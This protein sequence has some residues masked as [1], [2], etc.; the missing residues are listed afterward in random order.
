MPTAEEMSREDTYVPG[1]FMDYLSI[2]SKSKNQDAAWEFIKW[3]TTEGMLPMVPHGRIP[4]SSAFDPNLVTDSFS[5]G[6]AELFDL[7]S[8]KD[9]L[10]T[11]ENKYQL[12]TITDK[13]AEVTKIASEEFE[14]AYV[15]SKTP[16]EALQSAKARGDEVLSK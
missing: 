4:A 12:S 11:P 15:G 3:Y 2:N 14:F 1:G 16:Q 10:L 6:V 13:L 9:Q 8:F 5:E 7:N